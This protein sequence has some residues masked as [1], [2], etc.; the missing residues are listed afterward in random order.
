M[1][2][3]QKAAAELPTHAC[4]VNADDGYRPE[5]TLFVDED[6]LALRAS[7]ENK[8]GQMVFR[9]C[10][11]FCSTHYKYV[12][13]T[14]GLRIVQVGIGTKDRRETHFVQPS[15]VVADPPGASNEAICPAPLC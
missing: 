8:M 3:V 14:E 6:W 1:A 15:E 4:S 12:K 10:V 2:D 9:P 7:R 5:A 13:D 11:R